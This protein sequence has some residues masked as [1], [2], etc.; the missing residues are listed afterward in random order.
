MYMDVPGSGE[1]DSSVR[2]VRGASESK[3]SFLNA[4]ELDTCTA[5]SMNQFFYNI[6]TPLQQ[7]GYSTHGRT[8]MTFFLTT[9][10]DLASPAFFE[11][12]NLRSFVV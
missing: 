7:C 1:H 10:C 11:A 3:S 6:A 9:T 4:S 12:K 2:V 8:E 5:K